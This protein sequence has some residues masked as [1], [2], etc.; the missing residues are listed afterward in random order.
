MT[1]R[2]LAELL[3][4]GLELIQQELEEQRALIMQMKT[5]QRFD[6]EQFAK[7][8]DAI[9]AAHR[10]RMAELLKE[11][12]SLQHRLEGYERDLDMMASARGVRR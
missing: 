9:E 8:L 2:K 5:Q 7:D 11:M 6:R 4:D 1:R 12:S 10:P 3:A